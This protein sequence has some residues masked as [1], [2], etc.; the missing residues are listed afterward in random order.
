MI[1]AYF[2]RYAGVAEFREEV[3]KAA[4]ETGVVHTL[5][6]RTRRTPEIRNRN[7][8]VREAAERA[9]FNTPIQGSAADL[10]KRAMLKVFEAF[11]ARDDAHLIMQV[12]DELVLEAREDAAEDIAREL[13]GLMEEAFALNVP[14]V[15]DTKINRSWI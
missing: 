8:V 2:E 14:L 12:H 3:L 6:G 1:H 4:R 5:F 9:A 13:K 10:M 11:E 7:R 15:V